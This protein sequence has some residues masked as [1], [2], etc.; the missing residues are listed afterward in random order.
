MKKETL[1]ELRTHA[2]ELIDGGIPNKEALFDALPVL[3]DLQVV[4][5]IAKKQ[6]AGAVKA[7]KQ[8]SELCSNY[9]LDH[10]SVFENKRLIANQQ[11]VKTGDIVR[12]DATYHFASGFDGYQRKNP[13]DK[14]T[15]DFLARLPETWRKM[16]LDI[17]VS[18]INA[19]GPDEEQLD[20]YGLAQ[21]PNN[22]WSKAEE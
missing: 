8:L 2:D 9:A 14:M 7:M 16:K 10:E 3:A 1:K 19:D 22:V 12:E 21:K 15:Q 6:L 11:G 5:E 18:G 4:T 13:R 17:N 20:K